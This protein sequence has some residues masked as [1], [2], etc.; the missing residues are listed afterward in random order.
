MRAWRKAF[1]AG[2]RSGAAASLLSTAMLLAV[3]R[4]ETGWLFAPTN[5][6]SQWVWGEKALRAHRLTWR[7]TATGYLI[8]HAASVFWATLH[9]RVVAEST[10]PVT[11]S[12]ALTEGLVTA[13]V[14]C[15]VDYQLT[16]R[17]LTP[18]FE[19]R[20]SRRAMCCVYA[21]FGLGIAIMAY[22]R[23][24]GRQGRHALSPEK[25]DKRSSI[26]GAS[27]RGSS[28]FMR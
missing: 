1:L 28:R 8:H 6:T 22:T 26:A 14:A 21:A 9:A 27:G 17:R 2:L 24:S 23:P 25:A 4:K 5:A 12:R 7:H 13:A 3:G 11:R 16:P 10:A 18:G 19:H 15:F 20:L